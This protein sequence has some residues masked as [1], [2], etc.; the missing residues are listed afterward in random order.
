MM[1][2]EKSFEHLKVIT[3]LQ[4]HIFN[5]VVSYLWPETVDMP[6]HIHDFK[7]GNVVDLALL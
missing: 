7:F 2:C 6:A 1:L 5:L 3:R 4:C